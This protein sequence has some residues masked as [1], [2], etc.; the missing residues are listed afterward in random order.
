MTTAST[1]DRIPA[2]DRP[3]AQD[4]PPSCRDLIGVLAQTDRRDAFAALALGATSAAE[5][6]E[7]AGLRPAAA[8]AALSKLVDGRIA[9][10]DAD[11]RTY[12]LI[13]DTFRLAVQAEVR[14]SGRGGGDG[15][16]AYFRKG[17]LTSIPGKAETRTRVLS[18]VA[19]SFE[20]GVTYAEAKVNAI[21][22][23]WFDDWVTLRRALVDEELLRRDESGTR[24]ERV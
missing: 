18:V 1:D 13:E 9:A 5:V 19:D 2:E 12:R 4:L 16:G 15:A 20:P 7:R 3:R 10:Y 11:A 6:A 24:Y 23:Q 22:G 14:I 17:R 21:C 8:A